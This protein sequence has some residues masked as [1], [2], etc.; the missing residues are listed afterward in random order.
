MQVDAR[1]LLADCADLFV[2]CDDGT[3][4]P[5][6]KFH[7]SRQ[8]QILFWVR[9]DVTD[10]PREVPFPGVPS[11]NL[12]L[13]LDIIHEISK[14]DDYSL[15]QVDTAGKGFDVLG[16][17]FDTSA[18][19][20]ELV[21]TTASIDHLRSRL[22]KLMRSDNVKRNDVISKVI[23]MAPLYDDVILTM[24]SCQPD[25]EMAVYLAITLGKYVPIV[26]LVKHIIDTVPNM[27]AD[28][29]IRVAGCNGIGTYIH[30]R[31]VSEILGFVRDNAYYYKHEKDSAMN[32]TYSFIRAMAS[33][34]HT[35][36][37]VPLSCST[38]NGS[39][40]MF[41]DAQ[42]VSLYITL[43][44][45][46]P[47]RRIKMAKWITFSLEHGMAV[48]HIR[49]HGIDMASKRARCMDVRMFARTSGQYAE[50]WYSWSKPTWRPMVEVSTAE[51]QRVTGDKAVFDAVIEAGLFSK[52]MTIR[53]DV[54][55]GETS[56]L[57]HPPLF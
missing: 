8:C 49:A 2:V 18:R 35:Y 30:P 34:M 16:C 4:I 20:W 1:R 19:V 24:K 47:K 55:Y 32:A 42:S 43:D 44:G 17:A 52:R 33:A 39:L 3:R 12:I 13:A 36:D 54:F 31:E 6:S 46:P 38:L 53:I 26:P 56:A 40:I 37:F 22:P 23:T 5:C 10:M 25:A 48:A 29:I 41:H 15:D 51:C 27:T 7:V 14:I 11:K 50:V 9:E 28:Q 57:E 45:T 21:R